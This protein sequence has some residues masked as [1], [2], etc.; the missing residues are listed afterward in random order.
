MSGSD[1][2]NCGNL[3]VPAGPVV[4]KSDHD[5]SKARRHTDAAQSAYTNAAIDANI[6]SGGEKRGL[7]G[8]PQ[9]LKSAKSTYLSA[10]YSGPNDRR[11]K[12]GMIKKTEI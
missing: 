2:Q 3:P 1:E 10:E 9:T 7:R 8:G 11:P 6:L 5:A 12:P 4:D